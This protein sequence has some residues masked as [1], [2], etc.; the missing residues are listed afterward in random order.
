MPT[1]VLSRRR[2]LLDTGAGFGWLALSSLLQA[3]TQ[4][5][6][7]PRVKRVVQVFCAGGMSHLDTFDYKPLLG[8]RDGKP[9]EM[10]TFFGQ[11]GNLFA[12]PWAFAQRGQSGLWVSGLLPH[13]ARVADKL[14]V[15]RTMVAK[16]ANHMPAIAQANTGFI[17]TGF[18]SM[19]AW[20]TYA[21]GSESENLPAFVVLPDPRGVPWGGSVLWSNGFLP[22]AH[23]GTAFR[24]SGD[25]VPDLADPKDT[26]PEA[27]RDALAWLRSMNERYAAEHPGESSLEAR[28]R[29]YEMAASMQLTVPGIAD[30]TRESAATQR[31]Y[32]LDNKD[33]APMARNCL[34]ARRLLESG[35]RFV[36]VYCGG[37][38]KNWDAHG[39]LA[40]N[41]A[42]MAIEYD[43]P[44][45][46]LLTDL[47]SRGML[48]DTLVM[49]V[50]E[51]GRTP[52]AQGAGK[53][54]RDHHPDCFTCWFAGGGV[55]PGIAYGVSDE[56]GR[57]PLENPVTV[58]D[59]HATAL[60]L[61]G[62]DHERLTYYHNGIQR[63]L[64]D[65]HGH[66]VEGVLSA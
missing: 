65:V 6:R 25:P 8:E 16:S 37:S 5:H 31:L 29:S 38:G 10:P 12:S 42:T 52:V 54:G 34:L 35:V 59:Y 47:E 39:D 53:R 13:L 2:L 24:A 27:R 50:T 45:A 33:T 19:G 63:R 14:T 3:G 56:V 49:G 60:H 43:Q 62:L 48:D 58:H 36:Q 44:V 4:P 1:N 40:G 21:L 32:G 61:L 64:T 55:R 26:R 66:V 17:L 57:R 7:K 20:V 51:F 46:A 30:L 28:V 41:H 11:A 18:P 23:Q 22:A 9:Y 15:I